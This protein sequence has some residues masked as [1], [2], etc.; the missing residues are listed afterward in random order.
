MVAPESSGSTWRSIH[1]GS[2]GPGIFLPPLI[3]ESIIF[4]EGRNPRLFPHEGATVARLRLREGK[5]N[6]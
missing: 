2:N 6:F 1:L 3:G 4:Y 5:T